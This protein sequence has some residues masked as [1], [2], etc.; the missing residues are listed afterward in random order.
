[1]LIN[2]SSGTFDNLLTI[3]CEEKS[4]KNMQHLYVNI[5][6]ASFIRSC[7]RAF[8]RDKS[9]YRQHI[10]MST[11]RTPQCTWHKRLIQEKYG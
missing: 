3:V 9:I 1:M 8:I 2:S 4:S 7:H 10:L 11:I 6:F 5:N